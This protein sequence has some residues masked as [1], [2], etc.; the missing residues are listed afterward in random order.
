MSQQVIQYINKTIRVSIPTLFHEG[1]C[2]ALKL[3]D[4]ELRGL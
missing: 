1:K 4:V 3:I 2:R